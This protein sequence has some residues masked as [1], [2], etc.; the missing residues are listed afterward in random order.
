MPTQ[1]FTD[2]ADTYTV[3]AAGDYSL[4]FLGG[5]DTLNVRGGT[6][7]IASMGEGDDL[8]RL[9]S[10]PAT[11]YLEDGN[12]RAYIWAPGVTV[13]GGGDDDQFFIRG[14][15]D[16]TVYGDAGTDRI[17]FYCNVTNVT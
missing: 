9:Y 10:G 2:N 15:S 11:V 3:A 13:Y 17:S 5:N 6:S 12:D 7:T 14:G 4:I 16:Q 1:F 8:V